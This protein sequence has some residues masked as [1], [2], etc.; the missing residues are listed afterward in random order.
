MRRLRRTALSVRPKQPYIDWANALDEDGPRISQDFAGEQNIY[1]VE[2]MAEGRFDLQAIV[3]PHYA[4]IFE[5]ELGAWH[6]VESDW[7]TPRNF[8]TFQAWFEVEVHSLVLDLA[9]GWLRTEPYE[10]Y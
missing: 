2:D 1:L 9:G 6:R 5:E 10:R 3:E 7:P 8:A 4:A